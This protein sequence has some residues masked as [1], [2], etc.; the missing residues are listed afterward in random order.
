M[1]LIKKNHH[2]LKKIVNIGMSIIIGYIFWTTFSS[3]QTITINTQ[4]PLC[5]YNIP[6]QYTIK[7]PETITV[8]LKGNKMTLLQHCNTNELSCHIDIRELSE[9]INYPIINADKLFLPDTIKLVNY[10]K[11]PVSI[12]LFKKTEE[13]Y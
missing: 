8:T 5:F 6:P 2:Y 4:V 11:K 10:T 13:T 12:I 7:A 1:L 9:G 3:L